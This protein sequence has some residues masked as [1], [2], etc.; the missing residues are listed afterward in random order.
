MQIFVKTLTGKTITLEVEPSDSIDNVK[1]KIQ[2]K[3]GIPP[4]QQRLIFAGK[5]LEDGRT[6]SDYN[7]QKESTLH[8]VLR[9]RG[10]MDP[11]GDEEDDDEDE[12]GNEGDGQGEVEGGDEDDEED[13]AEV[14]ISVSESIKTAE[15]EERERLKREQELLAKLRAEEEARMRPIYNNEDLERLQI[16]I[17]DLSRRLKNAEHTIAAQ[18]ET[19]SKNVKLEETYRGRI[20]EISNMLRLETTK[21]ASQQRK[22]LKVVEATRYENEKNRATK[23]HEDLRMA[24]LDHDMTGMSSEPLKLK[25]MR[26]KMEEIEKQQDS[27]KLLLKQLSE[28]EAMLD[29]LCDAAQRGKLEE[30]HMLLRKGCGV[31]EVDSAGYLPLYYASSAGHVEVVRLLLEYGAD[32]S[33]YLSGYSSIEI[34]ARNGHTKVI[35]MLLKFGANIEDKGHSGSSPLISAVGGGHLEAVHELLQ[36]RANILACNFNEDTAL[37]VAAGIENPVYMI[38]LLLKYGADKKSINRKGHTPVRVALA[39][40]NSL[41]IEALGG[42]GAMLDLD[43]DCVGQLHS[44]VGQQDPIAAAAAATIGIGGVVGG[45]AAAEEADDVSDGVRGGEAGSRAGSVTSSVTFY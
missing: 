21:N 2:D 15:R 7:I 35:K 23:L 18:R 40:A 43:G 32:S 11:E 41:A 3:E 8:L 9:L 1:A 33:S 31:N 34:A 10:G 44:R 42:R 14:S 22:A 29:Q 28:F 39:K 25:K 36:Q 6:L 17:A 16:V 20:G 38:R 37:H 4:D 30:V 27:Q 19:T 13:T 45:G 24:K 5:Q 26:A 12:E